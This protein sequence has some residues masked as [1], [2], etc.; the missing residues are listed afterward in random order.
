VSDKAAKCVVFCSYD[1]TNHKSSNNNGTM[2]KME[3]PIPTV[4]FSIDLHW[5]FSHILINNANEI[6]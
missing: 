3:L 2:E 6:V 5:E 1:S 4:P